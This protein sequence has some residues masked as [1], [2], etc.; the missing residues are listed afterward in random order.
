[1]HGIELSYVCFDT[2]QTT[3]TQALPSRS[4]ISG[5]DLHSLS[6]TFNFNV[7]SFRNHKNGKTEFARTGTME[8]GAV[9]R[10]QQAP[11]LWPLVVN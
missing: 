5:R 9:D 2:E 10:E 1:M 8:A 7:T 3:C 4:K 11:D 6:K